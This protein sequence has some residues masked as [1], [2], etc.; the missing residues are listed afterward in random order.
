MSNKILRIPKPFELPKGKSLVL[1]S[2][3]TQKK[4]VIDGY[5]FKATV[6]TKLR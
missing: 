5:E 6:I 3:K 1:D 2:K 4:E